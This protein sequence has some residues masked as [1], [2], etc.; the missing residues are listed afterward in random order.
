MDETG[1]RQLARIL[2]YIRKDDPA[3]A[4]RVKKKIAETLAGLDTMEERFHKGDVEGTR[5][6]S[7]PP[8]PYIAVYEIS[9]R[10]VHILD[11]RHGAQQWPPP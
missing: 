2:R 11:I 4:L 1:T 10:Q 3:A 7:F 5:E 9:E 8:W 6:V